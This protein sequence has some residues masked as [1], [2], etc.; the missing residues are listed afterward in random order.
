MVTNRFSL[1]FRLKK[2]NSRVKGNVPV[3]MRLTVDGKRTELSVDREFDPQRWNKKF[4]RATGTKEDAKTLNA[5]L[6]TLQIKVHEAQAIVGGQRIYY[7]RKTQ[8]QITGKRNQEISN[9]A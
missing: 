2:P 9:V 4:G 7:C 5:Y 8:K 3:Y 1:L 6:D